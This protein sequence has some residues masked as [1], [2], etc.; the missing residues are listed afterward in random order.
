[1]TESLSERTMDCFTI[2]PT[3]CQA[4]TER[5]VF[6][7]RRILVFQIAVRLGAPLRAEQSEL[8]ISDSSGSLL[9]AGGALNT[10]SAR[11]MHALGVVCLPG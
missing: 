3:I 7:D 10:E 8:S 6:K 11:R 1:M 5:E 9:F 2:D 4:R